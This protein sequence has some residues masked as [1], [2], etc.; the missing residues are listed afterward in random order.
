M[1]AIKKQQQEARK[2][3]TKLRNRDERIQQ[4]EG[5]R[6]QLEAIHSLKPQRDGDG[7]G[8]GDGGN[9]NVT[10]SVGGQGATVKKTTRKKGKEDSSKSSRRGKDSTDGGGKKEGK[11]GEV[12]NI[13]HSIKISKYYNIYTAKGGSGD[14]VD[15]ESKK[16]GH[17]KG[18]KDEATKGG[19][20]KCEKD[21]G[22]LSQGGYFEKILSSFLPVNLI[23][24]CLFY[25]QV[26]Q[27]P[28]KMKDVIIRRDPVVLMRTR[29][30]R[31]SSSRNRL[32]L[33]LIK[34][35]PFLTLIFQF[36][37]NNHN[38]QPL[39]TFPTHVYVYVFVY[40]L[41]PNKSVHV[42]VTI[43]SPLGERERERER[44]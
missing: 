44:E 27:S 29:V 2:I 14:N 25:V 8:D 12:F 10:P 42:C 16:K 21:G 9:N 20:K 26:Q 39:W 6:G 11:K 38:I 30:P 7:D 18:E 23:F 43:F 34:Y 31:I 36:S 4:L 32:Y 3:S 13:C 41:S 33:I 37:F 28:K 19:K 24:F 22:S 35:F 15:D 5:Q 40:H 1:Q 17:R